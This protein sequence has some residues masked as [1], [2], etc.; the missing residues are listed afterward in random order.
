[1]ETT[2]HNTPLSP[3]ECRQLLRSQTVGRIGWSSRVGQ[4]ILPVSYVLRDDQIVFRTAVGSVLSDLVTPQQV[5]F[6][7]DDLD[8]ETLTGWSV[9]VQAETAPAREPE[10][11]PLP[12]APGE[13]PV[14]VQLTPSAFSGRVIAAS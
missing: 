11:S 9:T 12:W 5:C 13:R 10:H 2:G 1:M 8:A 3:D 7:I 6:E 4:V 14:F